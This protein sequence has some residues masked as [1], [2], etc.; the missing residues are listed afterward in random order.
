MNKINL[1]L[2]VGFCWVYAINS[3]AQTSEDSVANHRAFRL[4]H[5]H[6]YVSSVLKQGKPPAYWGPRNPIVYV[7]NGKD[8]ITLEPSWRVTFIHPVK[9]I[10]VIDILIAKTDT[11]HI[12]CI[13]QEFRETTTMSFTLYP[14][15]TIPEF[16]SF[17]AESEP[18]FFKKPRVNAL[19]LVPPD[20]KIELPSGIRNQ[21]Q[22]AKKR[23]IDLRKK[24]EKVHNL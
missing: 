24:N 6:G 11:L 13:L 15:D 14:Q 20:I 8:T 1:V 22:N 7:L 2:L 17:M 18:R 23:K 3:N 19:V 5:V 10:E 4:V 21:I 12:A 16:V 9:K